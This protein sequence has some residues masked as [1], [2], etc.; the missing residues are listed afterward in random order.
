MDCMLVEWTVLR[1]VCWLSG[2]YCG[3]YA[4]GVD[5]IVDCMLVEWTVLWTVCCWSG[6]YCGLYAGGVDFDCV[7]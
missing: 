4:G 3:L 1:T 6:L 2:L 5:C 7:Q